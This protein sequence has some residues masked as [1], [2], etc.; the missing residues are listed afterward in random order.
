MYAEKAGKD[1]RNGKGG[2]ILIIKER[3]IIPKPG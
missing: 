2:E 1:R 3:R